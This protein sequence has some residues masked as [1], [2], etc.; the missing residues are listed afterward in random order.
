MYNSRD[1]SSF[2]YSFMDPEIT[3]FWRMLT[4][5]LRLA[6]WLASCINEGPIVRQSKIKLNILT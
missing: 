6:G 2:N 5:E 3:M 4:Y 1:N